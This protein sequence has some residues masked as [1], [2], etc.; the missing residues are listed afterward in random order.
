MMIEA[1]KALETSYNDVYFVFTVQEEVGCR[2]AVTAAERIKPDIGLAVDI[3]PA[4]DIPG[5]LTGSNTVGAG[6]AIKV[7]DTSVIC[8]EYLVGTL[9]ELCGQHQI[10]YQLDVIYV[11]GTDA[12]AINQ[13]HFGVKAAGLSVVTR[14]P[15][16]AN[17]LVNLADVDNSIRLL[18]HFVNEPFQF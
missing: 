5:D 11:G 15:H 7:S 8:D 1:V 17:T 14:Y 4:H 3:T 10:P 2:G 16:C 9:K 6:P 13:S 18:K 12:S